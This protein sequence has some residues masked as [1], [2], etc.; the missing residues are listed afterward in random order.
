VKTSAKKYIVKEE[1]ITQYVQHLQ[2]LKWA[3]EIRTRTRQADA[4]EK[5]NKSFEDYE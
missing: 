2:E 1:Y 3:K 5:K 4:A